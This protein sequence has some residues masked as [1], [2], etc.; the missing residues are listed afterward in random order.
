MQNLA[1]HRRS[2]SLTVPDFSADSLSRKLHSGGGR[3]P[4]SPCSGPM[5]TFTHS[6]GLFSG[7]Q[8][9]RKIPGVPGKGRMGVEWCKRN[10]QSDGAQYWRIFIIP[11]GHRG[12]VGSSTKLWK[13]MEMSCMVQLGPL[14]GTLG[15][16]P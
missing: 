1:L 9:E 12:R 6:A 2:L 14:S 4:S 11:R 8:G 5:V 13:A 16:Q 10:L 7:K 3:P 15:A